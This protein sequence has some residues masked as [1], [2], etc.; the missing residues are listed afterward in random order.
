MRN[1]LSDG[2]Q[3]CKVQSALSA[4]K[5]IFCGVPQGSV[6]G[7]LI[8]LMLINDLPNCVD[9]TTPSIFADDTTNTLSVSDKRN[10]ADGK[11][12]PSQCC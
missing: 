5:P 11:Q 7:S 10:M 6:L 4:E 8:F 1:H 9:H 12:T 3:S 2:V